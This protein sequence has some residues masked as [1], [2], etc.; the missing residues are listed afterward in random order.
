MLAGL[1]ALSAALLAASPASAVVAK[2]QYEG[3]TTTIG[4]QP[5]STSDPTQPPNG[6]VS[7]GNPS[8]APVV[9]SSVD[10]AIYWDPEYGFHGDWEHVVNGFLHN[11]GQESGTRG[12]VDSVD[13]QYTD[14]SNGHASYAF[15]FRGAYTDRT[16][17]PSNGCVDPDTLLGF[18]DGEAK[19]DNIACLTDAQVKK[20]LQE[21]IASNH[22]H[23]GMGTIFYMFT[24]PGVTVCID[25]G[26]SIA[27]YCSD[28][29]PAAESQGHSFCSYHSAISPGNPTE[30]DESTILYATIP[31]TA[32]GLGDF[33]LFDQAPGYE[34][35]DGGYDPTTK[36]IE[37][38]E[39]SP[40]QQEPNHI[41]GVGPDGSFDTGLADLIVNQV[42]VE[43][44]DIATDPLLNAW[45]DAEG[46]EVTD[47][48]RNFFAVATIGGTSAAKEETDAGTLFNQTIAGGDYYLNDT[49]D[50]AALL[51]R[52]PAIPCIPG[53][54]LEP[55]F[56]SPNAVNA[57]DIVGF[58]AEESDAT[59][60]AGVGYSSNG[61]PFET[62]PT[63]T[64]DFGDGTKTTSA[65]P[66]GAS[67]V[68]EPSA[69]HSYAYGGA[70]TVTLTVTDVGGNTS[71]TTRRV[72]VVGPPPPSPAAPTSTA[73]TSAA[74]SGAAPSTSTQSGSTVAKT[75]KGAPAPS[76]FE[77]IGS[78]SLP[79]V[80]HKGLI[81][82][83]GVNEQVAGNV[84]VMIATSTAKR[85]HIHGPIA[86]HLP[87][88]DPR[89]TV[90]G[91][92]VLVTTRRGHGT[93]QIKLSPAVKRALSAMTRLKVTLRIVVRNASRQHPKTRT[94]ISSFDLKG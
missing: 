54:M 61:E 35:Q 28:S 75:A 85:L 93:L 83:Y 68:D 24:P 78:H 84:E 51:Q 48:C 86:K 45:Q 11:L 52:Y 10:Y 21:F 20:E 49:F 57:G 62:Y 58:D 80:L 92:A 79:T 50:F 37:E 90:I 81:V 60:D 43:Q 3:S 64:W 82:H 4:M 65:Y 39:S 91:T 25:G 87:K 42:S 69:F 66:L 22:L 70:Y 77:H 1:L 17:Y 27:A 7:F 14:K 56:T 32:G 12:T 9:H 71:S 73:P 23:A 38:P 19:K 31:W 44:R 5:R 36:P 16:P 46:N 34:C 41:T 2:V 30:G 33:Q 94:L 8:G 76:V 47:E 29:A 18:P 89:Q 6:I 63:Y 59:L 15:T 13:E 74:P 67:R 72:T 88:G 26:G 55:Q 40:T 53:I